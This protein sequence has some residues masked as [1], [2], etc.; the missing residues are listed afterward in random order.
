M[1]KA[2]DYIITG[3]GCA[4]LSL[5]MRMMQEP[6]LRHKKILVID[7]D[8]QKS[9][10]RTWCFWEADSGLF[11]PIVYHRWQQL[12]FLAPAIDRSFSIA[13][14]QYKMIRGID[15]YDYVHSNAA[16]YNNIAFVQATV[17]QVRN[18][19]Q[20]VLVE[21][22]NGKYS[23]TYVFNSIVVATQLPPQGFK[24]YFL[25]QHF[26]GKII[27]TS[28]PVFD[29]EKATLMDFTVHQVN[30]TT[31]MY[32]LPFSPTTALV[33]YTLFTKELLL[34]QQ[35]DA[36]IDAYLQDTYKLSSYT[37]LHEEFGKI[38]MTNYRF[39]QPEGGIIP[40]GIAGG[41]AKGSSGYAFYFIQQQTA[42]IV[43][44][45]VAQLYPAVP[46]TIQ[47]RKFQ[48]FDSVLLRV[49][50]ERLMPGHVIF[51]AIFTHNKPTTIL[52]FLNN[53]SS[54]PEDLA[55]MRSLPMRVFLP[56]AL[57]TALFRK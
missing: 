32:V 45:L 34:P 54:I 21:T 2:F 36:A 50:E 13:P 47:Q 7:K 16:P 24:G 57:H 51:S 55:I 26:K 53:E 38:P 44:R 9:N 6:A 30:G 19:P 48:W 33:E 20:G 1:P 10:D 8:T 17:H 49:L 23:A 11:E 4:G 22:D 56:A 46:K 31:F 28:T 14:Y 18:T 35:Y 42:A 37:V 40:I 39:A 41:Q 29:A 27:E 5:L 15:F 52:R 12:R 43:N 3:A 25:W